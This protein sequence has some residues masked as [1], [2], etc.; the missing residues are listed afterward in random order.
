MFIISPIPK[1]SDKD[2]YLPLNYR[3]I[4][5]NSCLAE[6]FS[7][8]LNKRIVSYCNELDLLVDEQNA[9]QGGHVET[10]SIL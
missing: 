3:G 1:C 6:V 5:I 10:T 8:I 7:S 9:V 2:P 4:Y